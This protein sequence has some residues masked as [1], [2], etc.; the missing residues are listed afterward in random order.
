VLERPEELGLPV[1]A[2]AVVDGDRLCRVPGGTSA[3]FDLEVATDLRVGLQRLR[4]DSHN[5]AFA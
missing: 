5:G 2:A 1:G 4:Q 3:G